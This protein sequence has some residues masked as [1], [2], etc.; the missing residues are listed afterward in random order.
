MSTA[1]RILVAHQVPAAR[2]GG[3]SRIMGFVHDRLAARGHQIDYFTADDVPAKWRGAFGRRFGFP[4]LVRQVVRQ[5]ANDGRPYE[6]VNVHEPHAMAVTFGH[7]QLGRPAIVVTSHG[8]ERRAWQLAKDE[9]RLGRAPLPLKTRLFY[10]PT[11]LWQ[12][13]VGLRRAHHVLC[14]NADDREC[15][16]ADFGR[17]ADSVTRIFPGADVRYARNAREYDRAERVLFA[18]AWRTNKGISDLVP[19]FVRL[20]A[21]HPS[22]RL[23]VVGAGVPDDVVLSAFPAGVRNRIEVHAPAEE[24]GTVAVFSTA[25][26]FLLPSLF[27]G[28]PLTLMQAMM[29]GLPIVTT[30]TCGMKEAI[31]DGKTGLLI[32]LR[33]PDA[34]EAAIDRLVGDRVLRAR[35]GSGARADALDRFT[36]ER[37]AEPVEDAY[38]RVHGTLAQ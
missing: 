27:E 2:T 29:S 34:I 31:A 5:A 33:T 4:L 3:M 32:P 1:L 23:V 6:V 13:T 12:G 10:P 37:V 21:R 19:A 7:E 16:I 14:L 20:A 38:R 22:L 9:A 15:L 26:L 24:E 28:T 36:W 17:A 18:G 35:I 30:R 11:S 25:D 8:L